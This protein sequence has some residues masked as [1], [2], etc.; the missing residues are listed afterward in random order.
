MNDLLWI[1]RDNNSEV[2]IYESDPEWVDGRWVGL[3]AVRIK[4]GRK[5]PQDVLENGHKNPLG[6]TPSPSF[7]TAGDTNAA[8][9]C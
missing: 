5:W 2:W 1:A 6:T 4:G 9:M 8:S 7:V 3:N